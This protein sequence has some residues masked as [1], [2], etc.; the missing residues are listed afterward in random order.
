MLPDEERELI[1]L[2]KNGDQK[3]FARLVASVETRLFQ[4]IYRFF[5]N[6]DEAKDVLQETLLQAYLGLKKF[7]LKSSFYTWIYR[8]AV[9]SCSRRVSSSVFKFNRSSESLDADGN[10][11]LAERVRREFVSK[12]KSAREV[13]EDEENRKRVRKAI[14]ALPRKFF[15]VVMLHDLEE[16]NVEEVAA[17]LKVPKGTV[18][19][20]VNRAH[21]KLVKK[22]REEGLRS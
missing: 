5:G 3:A 4:M 18:M 10:E 20:R 7:E 12:Q 9:R 21:H 15:E 8:I 16:L 19:S 13:A 1:R 22:L 6:A 2:A 11:S 17:I 14:S